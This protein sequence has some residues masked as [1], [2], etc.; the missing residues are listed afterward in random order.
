MRPNKITHQKYKNR[1][2]EPKIIY[3]KQIQVQRPTHSLIQKHFKNTK[4]EDIREVRVKKIKKNIN[5]ITFK[6]KHFFKKAEAPLFNVAV[7]SI[8]C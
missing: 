4:L 5:K 8:F 2:K 6:L 7:K 3:K 1:K